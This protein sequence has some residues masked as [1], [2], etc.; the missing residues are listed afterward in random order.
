MMTVARELDE[1]AA[2]PILPRIAPDIRIG[3]LGLGNVGSAAGC[4]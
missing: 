3:L 4:A 1:N 2:A